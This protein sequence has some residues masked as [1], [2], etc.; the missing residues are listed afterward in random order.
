MG[1]K[2]KALKLIK[3]WNFR[4]SIYRL[5]KMICIKSLYCKDSDIIPAYLAW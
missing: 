2:Y 4:Y 5:K 3:E 1:L